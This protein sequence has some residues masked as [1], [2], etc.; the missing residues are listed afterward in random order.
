MSRKGRKGNQ[1]RKVYDILDATRIHSVGS[2][3]NNLSNYLV[4]FEGD[5]PEK[6]V[7]IVSDLLPPGVDPLDPEGNQGPNGDTYTYI[8]NNLNKITHKF[9]IDWSTF[10]ASISH[11]IPLVRIIP[12]TF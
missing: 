2:S 4:Q 10:L 8:K 11:F 1:P 12:L 6:A 5:P 9:K 3:L 7:W